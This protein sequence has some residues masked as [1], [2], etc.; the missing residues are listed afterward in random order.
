MVTQMHPINKAVQ[1]LVP[2]M[3]ECGIAESPVLLTPD[4]D[5]PK[6]AYERGV[7]VQVLFGGRSAVFVSD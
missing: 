6:C 5:L 2:M 7:P 4:Y 1:A 3:E